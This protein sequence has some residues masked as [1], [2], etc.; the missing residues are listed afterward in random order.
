SVTTSPPGSDHVPVIAAVLPAATVTEAEVAAT[1]GGALV[2]FRVKLVD[3]LAPSLS[4]AVIVIVRLA[5][6]LPAGADHDH[7]PS[8]L[9]P[10]LPAAA[11]SVTT[12]PPGSDHVPVIAAVEPS[13]AVTDCAAAATEGATL[14]TFTPKE[15]EVLAPSLSVAVTVTVRLAG[16][17][18][19]GADHDH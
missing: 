9:R 3:L 7:E 4:V 15:V 19:A 17:L 16:P 11:A 13:C 12:S 14:V 2:T 6:P 8:A 10:T 5:G 18:P 1:L